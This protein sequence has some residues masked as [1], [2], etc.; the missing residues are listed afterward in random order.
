MTVRVPS[1]ERRHGL[2]NERTVRLPAESR[3]SRRGVEEGK[4]PQ[5]LN[6]DDT[7][8]REQKRISNAKYR[9]A[10]HFEILAGKERYRDKNQDK[11]RSYQKKYRLNHPSVKKPKEQKEPDGL[12]KWKRWALKFPERARQAAIR[13]REGHREQERERCSK[14]YR[15]HPEIRH[16]SKHN[17]RARING[18]GGTYTASEWV[19]LCK[20][21]NNRCLCCNRSDIELTVD[22]VVPVSRGGTNSIDNIQPLC[23]CCNLKKGTKTIDYRQAA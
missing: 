18:N 22:H 6:M 5:G 17:R 1:G 12:S 8:R 23:T 14:F 16:A 15:Q 21:Y 10:H 7:T 13:Y 4:A 11:I 19:D 20:H 2:T 3:A 9:R